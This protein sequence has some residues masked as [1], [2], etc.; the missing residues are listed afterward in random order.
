M[1]TQ[2]SGEGKPVRR[3][4]HSKLNFVCSQSVSSSPAVTRKVRAGAGRGS[5][6]SLYCDDSQDINHVVEQ[7]QAIQQD[8]SQLAGRPISLTEYNQ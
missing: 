3:Y 2:N 4:F 7:I 5:K 1:R 8:I 6:A